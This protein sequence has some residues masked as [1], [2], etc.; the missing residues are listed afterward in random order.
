MKYALLITFNIIYL[1]I[2]K[3]CPDGQYL[4]KEDTC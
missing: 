2:A 1:A 4:D 3:T